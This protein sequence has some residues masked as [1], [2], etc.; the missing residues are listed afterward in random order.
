M[1]RSAHTRD[2]GQ[3][4]AVVL[5]TNEIASAI[6]VALHSK[7]ISVVLS[8]DPF[9]PV[10]RRK[11]AFYDALFDDPVTLGGVTPIRVDS[12]FEILSNRESPSVLITELGLLDLIVI[13]RFEFLIDAR[14]QHSQT[15]PDLRRLAGV[16]IGVGPGFVAGQNCDIAIETNPD[17]NA[18]LMREGSTGGPERSAGR[19]RFVYASNPGRWRTAADIGFRTFKNFIVGHLD[20]IAV[21]APFD[22][23]L[24]GVVRD[25]VEVVAG[26]RLLE[27]DPR[28]RRACWAGIDE[29]G[30]T[31]GRAITQALSKFTVATIGARAAL[32]VVK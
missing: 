26:A 18:R 11:M 17:R 23:F 16:A 7:R 4:F 8:H 24:R 9:S 20:G 22:G 21:A 12:G 6:A 10:I 15:T 3:P 1:A 28:G 2:R 13:R 14:M 5:G 25:G 31:T 30:W 29:R 19:D 27:I 32:Y